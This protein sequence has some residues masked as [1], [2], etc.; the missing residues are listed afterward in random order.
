MAMSSAISQHTPLI[1]PLLPPGE[2]IADWR[3]A[4]EVEGGTST[5]H[6]DHD[7]ADMT[8][9]DEGFLRLDQVGQWIGC[10]Q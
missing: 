10:G 1:D 8:L 9:G 3:A 6:R 5:F 7:V 2:K 4:E